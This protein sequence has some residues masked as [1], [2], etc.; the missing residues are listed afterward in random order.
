MT[1]VTTPLTL[2]DILAAVRQRTEL[3]QPLP[4]APAPA[5]LP[6]RLRHLCTL[7]QH[8]GVPDVWIRETADAIVTSL[9]QLQTFERDHVDPRR[10]VSLARAATM[11]NAVTAMRRA[12][13][14]RGEAVAALCVRHRLSRGHVYALL[15]LNMCGDFTGQKAG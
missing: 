7:A 2:A 5:D 11:A 1:I 8:S 10:R 13:H 14:T 15:R 4:A 12:G 9:L 6:G 3:Q